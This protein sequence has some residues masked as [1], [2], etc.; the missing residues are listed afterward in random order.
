MDQGASDFYKV[1]CEY[2][3]SSRDRLAGENDLLFA[4]CMKAL[5]AIKEAYSDGSNIEDLKKLGDEQ[6]RELIALLERR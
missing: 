1:F 6:A 3:R 4:I 2:Y 5:G